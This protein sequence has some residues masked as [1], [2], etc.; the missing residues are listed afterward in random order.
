MK[1]IELHSFRCTTTD[2]Q[3]LQA[4]SQFTGHKTFN[5]SA[6]IRTAIDTRFDQLPPQVK[7]SIQA[8]ANAA[9]ENKGEDCSHRLS[10]ASA[11]ALF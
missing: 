9:K 5:F 3:K 4:I 10:D 11:P 2:R 7:A 8:G 6:E 1:K